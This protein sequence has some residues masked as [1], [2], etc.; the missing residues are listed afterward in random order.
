[1][2]TSHLNVIMR[3]YNCV[4]ITNCWLLDLA[5]QFCNGT[6]LYDVFPIIDQLKDRYSASAVAK[7]L[8]TYSSLLD[9]T[10]NTLEVTVN[11]G[12]MQSLTFTAPAVTQGDIYTQI[13]NRNFTDC[14]VYL[15][16]G[17]IVIETNEK[18]P[19]TSLSLGGTCDLIWAL[20]QGAGYDI[21]TRY[22]HGAYRIKI[23]PP[24]GQF[25]NHVEMD[26]PVGCY[27]IWARVCHGKNEETSKVMQ[28]IGNCGEC[29]T[30]DLLLPEV[31]NCAQDI[32][33]PFGEK[34][35][36]DMLQIVP[37]FN[38]RVVVLKAM[39]YVAN[40]SREQILVE[41]AD[42]KQDALDINRTDLAARVDA[43]LMVA[44]ALPQ[45]C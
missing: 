17:R 16:D 20:E 25:I 1:M 15:Q 21:S 33:Y 5:V 12:T 39:A 37:E 2:G 9:Q 26:V 8:T 7:D 29:F 14:K 44:Q 11:G 35:A 18:G 34:V 31:M 6:P 28:V 27:K 19:N 23:Q 22:Y 42:R 30:V 13:K 36:N 45:C 41:L 32:I 38:D 3:D 10:G 40:L 43:L 4:P 24:S